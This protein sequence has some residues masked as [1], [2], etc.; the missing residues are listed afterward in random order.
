MEEEHTLTIIR[1]IL[2][3]NLTLIQ[4]KDS[5]KFFVFPTETMAHVRDAQLWKNQD[6]HYI[7]E[8]YTLSY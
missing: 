7:W 1:L 2:S 4:L 3:T 8:Y 5:L 6:K